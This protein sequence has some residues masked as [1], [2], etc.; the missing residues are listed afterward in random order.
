MSKEVTYYDFRAGAL[1]ET[2]MYSGQGC[3]RLSGVIKRGRSKKSEFVRL[4]INFQRTQLHC[5]IKDIRKAL[6]SER[7]SVANLERL[8]RPEP[9]E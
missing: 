5:L 7:G 9:D 8:L 1:C 3:F 2:V 4:R 6:K